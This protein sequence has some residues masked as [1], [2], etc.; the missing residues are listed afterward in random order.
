LELSVFREALNALKFKRFGKIRTILDAWPLGTAAFIDCDSPTATPI[1]DINAICRSIGVTPKNVGYIRTKR[2]WHI[3]VVLHETLS[4]A[5]LIAL[6]CILGSD[7]KREALNL[8][9]ARVQRCSAFWRSRSN[10]LFEYK[11]EK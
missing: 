3:I 11:V 4:E 1:P 9:R 6:Q 7:R 8:K 5:E 2:G 10:I